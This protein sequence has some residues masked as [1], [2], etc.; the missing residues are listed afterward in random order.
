MKGEVEDNNK[1][2]NSQKL[3]KKMNNFLLK[4]RLVE[5]NKMK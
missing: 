3:E 2:E 1:T 4:K 5:K